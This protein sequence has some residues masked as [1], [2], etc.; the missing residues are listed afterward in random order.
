MPRQSFFHKIYAFEFLN[1]FILLYTV[2]ALMFQA[3]GV[4]DTQLSFLFIFWSMAVILSNPIY[5][6]L[7]K[8]L[9]S[10]KVILLGQGCKGLCFL[11][12][13][14]FP[15]FSGY[16]L[17]FL[18]WGIQWAF[19]T[20]GWE[21]LIYNELI[22][23]KSEKLY[24]QV[25]SYKKAFH[26]MGYLASCFGSL[27]I[28]YGY[29]LI[30]ILSI[31]SIIVSIIVVSFMD[32]HYESSAP[33]IKMKEQIFQTFYILKKYPSVLKIVF[34]LTFLMGLSYIDEYFGIIGLEIGF[35]EKYVGSIYMAVLIIQI[36]F[37]SFAYRWEHL[38]DKELYKLIVFSGSLFSLICFLYNYIGLFLLLC[39][40]ALYSII[41][42]LLFSKIQSNVTSQTERTTFLGIFSIFEQIG[43]I[44]SYGAMMLATTVGSLKYG[45]VILGGG[46]IGIGL[47]YLVCE[48]INAIKG[49]RLYPP[50]KILSEED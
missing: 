9:S 49:K 1:A 18:F 20:R 50:P 4:S 17:G 32:C 46:V 5:D 36:L 25:C 12:W 15:F 40:Y 11:I 44:I 43:S 37:S 45:F 31:L 47:Y 42:V 13:Y 34:L 29:G 8:H 35:N 27:L 16:L 3:H 24:T 7:I 19:N 33:E 23:L 48:R 22:Y 28:G 6:F 41:E 2:Y 21:N 30:V 10:K 14:Y 39:F 38:K 26:Y